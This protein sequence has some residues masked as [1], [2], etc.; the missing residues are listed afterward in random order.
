[1]LRLN[2]SRG[3]VASRVKKM[4]DIGLTFA[5]V[6]KWVALICFS[7]SHRSERKCIWNHIRASAL[8]LCKAAV[9]SQWPTLLL[10]FLPALLVVMDPPG[11]GDERRRQAERL[12]REEAYYHFINDLSE[13][14]YRL[15]R[16]SNLL[17]TPGEEGQ[18][19]T[20]SESCNVI[21]LW[22]EMLLLLLL[23]FCVHRAKCLIYE[24]KSVAPVSYSFF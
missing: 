11:G 8:L 9:G 1:M 14:D 15:M 4:V 19:S 20:G 6:N 18:T 16:D 21:Y 3:S 12:R 24:N 2:V 7:A 10:I 5:P 22:V 23:F 17:G 13:E